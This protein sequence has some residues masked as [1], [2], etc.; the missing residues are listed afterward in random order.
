MKCLAQFV[1]VLSI[2]AIPQT[3]HSF[4]ATNGLSVEPVND[5]VFE[6][7]DWRGSP[8]SAFWCAAAN[9]AR[10]QLKTDWNRRLFVART[11]GPSVTSNRGAAVHF[12][13]NQDEVNAA[14]AGAGNSLASFVVGD[15]MTVQRANNYCQIGK[16]VFERF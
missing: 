9:Y 14:T 5:A 10:R 6:V 2:V 8:S 15:N 4:A 16:P 11:M 7:N 1:F 13:V 12:T 3:G